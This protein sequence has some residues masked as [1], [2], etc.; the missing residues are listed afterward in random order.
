MAERVYTKD[1]YDKVYDI[2]N[3]YQTKRDSFT[4]EQQEKIEW[5]F[6]EVLNN[7]FQNT[8]SD[9]PIVDWYMD[10]STWAVYQVRQNWD[11]EQ[12]RKTYDDMAKEV[13]QW[14]WWNWSARRTALEN[15]WYDYNEI[16]KRVNASMKWSKPKI[17]EDVP[18]AAPE[19]ANIPEPAP[20]SAPQTRDPNMVYPVASHASIE[21]YPAWTLMSDWTVVPASFN[22][23]AYPVATV[24]WQRT[25]PWWTIMS[26]WSVVP[27]SF[28]ANATPV[29]SAAWWWVIM[30]DWT[31]FNW[32]YPVATAAN[33]V[34]T[35]PAWT[36]MSDWTVFTW[37]YPVWTAA[38]QRVVADWTLMSDWT[39]VPASF[40]PWQPAYR[41]P[42]QD[43]KDNRQITDPRLNM[44]LSQWYTID[45]AWYLINPA[46]IS[47]F[48]R[49]I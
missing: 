42:Q 44:L 35:Y 14:K 22:A 40:V 45:N 37:W 26:D 21:T 9:N 7:A 6:S 32:A 39:V 3:E 11:T 16:Q 15:A 31:V 12:V 46:W 30:S 18:P 28:N 20:N 10:P 48:Q 19:P 49:V 23:S 34:E 8:S 27:A 33:K 24:A 36:R 2:Y 29:A 4:P 1:D 41:K 17:K 47:T 13:I 38:W 25:V 43:T 5:L